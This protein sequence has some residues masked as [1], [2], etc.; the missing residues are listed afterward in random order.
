MAENKN[1]LV[2]EIIRD[3]T[4]NHDEDI[5]FETESM[6]IEG[7]DSLAQLNIVFA[8]EAEFDIKIELGDIENFKKVGDFQDFV[9]INS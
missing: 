1:G 8:I 2:I 9:E 6:S 4:N 5:T 7:W 3:V